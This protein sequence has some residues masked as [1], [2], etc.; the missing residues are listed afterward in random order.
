MP[1]PPVTPGPQENPRKRRRPD[2]GKEPP[3]LRSF[4]SLESSQPLLSS[5]EEPDEIDMFDI[6]N[7]VGVGDR[8]D[9]DM[10][11]PIIPIAVVRANKRRKTKDAQTVGFARFAAEPQE[12]PS[13]M[14]VSPRHEEEQATIPTQPEPE[15]ELSLQEPEKK[16]PTWLIPY[17]SYHNK[18]TATKG[19]RISQ[20]HSL[21]T[22]SASSVI[23]SSDDS[24][25]ILSTNN[26]AY[27]IPDPIAS[28]SQK[29]LQAPWRV[30]ALFKD[31]NLNYHP[32]TVLES[33]SRQV[34]VEFDDSTILHL[35]RECVR[36]LDLR[37]GDVVR[38][39][40][41]AMKKTTYIIKDFPTA[42]QDKD[43]VTPGPEK[44]PESRQTDARGRTHVSLVPKT[45]PSAPAIDVLVTNLYLIK[46]L[47]SQFSDRDTSTKT[48]KLSFTSAY[49]YLQSTISPSISTS[50][51]VTIPTAYRR[52]STPLQQQIPQKS[53]L[54]DNMV[55]ALTGPT[56]STTLESR[57]LA[58]GGTIL[59]TGFEELFLEVEDSSTSL[60]LK[61]GMENIAF[62]AVISHAF[63][64]S[65][66]YLQALALGL[67]CLSE[68][69][70]ADCIKA[71]KVLEW[72]YYLLPAGETKRLGG[73]IKSQVLAG[74][75]SGMR[76]GE[77]LEKRRRVVDGWGILVLPKG[78]GA[79]QRKAYPFLLLALG[80]SRVMV[81]KGVEAVEKKVRD[82]GWDCV[83]CKEGEKGKVQRLGVRVVDD[84][85]LK[86]G[87]VFG[88]LD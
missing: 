66:K 67:P 79:E 28:Q 69:W 64:R 43:P 34:K 4:A 39:D 49:N 17:L 2:N 7:S 6:I 80:A 61:P 60:T 30:F 76:L 71:G 46:S 84:N 75:N 57:I 83:F 11:A 36:S 10:P 16:F 51:A 52:V 78:L 12:I 74:Y 47:W 29:P 22:A 59:Q 31:N 73:Q 41:P 44:S 35:G 82:G 1:P 3:D 25:D 37:I 45:D 8:P 40:L 85:E 48:L 24:S 70:I 88:K 68:K 23:S 5:Q 56:K 87:V 32:A 62:T 63:F 72:E 77:V 33:N 13:A 42:P 50:S 38:V 20:R 14:M 9:L 65:A 21:A 27:S 15:P 58:H 26:P 54:F 55:F 53:K 18:K 19:R 86:D 81:V